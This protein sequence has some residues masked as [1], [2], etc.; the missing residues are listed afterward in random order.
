MN[1]SLVTN[2][3]I[4]KEEEKTSFRVQKRKKKRKKNQ[5]ELIHE[6]DINDTGRFCQMFTENSSDID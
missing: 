1:L 2:H 6:I 4:E 3:E 5:N